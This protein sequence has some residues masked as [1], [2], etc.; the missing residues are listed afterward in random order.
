MTS[1]EIVNRNIYAMMA[2]AFQ[3]IRA[4]DTLEDMSPDAFDHLHD[5]CAE[6]LQRGMSRQVKLGL[7]HD[8]RTLS[9][10]IPTVR[11]KIDVVR[12]LARDTRARGR[13]VCEFDEYLP[14]TPHN[15]AIKAVI[16]LLLRHG[17]LKQERRTALRLLLPYLHAVRLVAPTEII[18]DEL[19]VNRL[20]ASY[21]QLLGVCELVVRGMIPHSSAGGLTLQPW[22]ADEAMDKLYERFLVEYF[23]FHHPSVFRGASQ[24]SWATSSVGSPRESQLP[25]MFSD[26]VLRTSNHT[27][28]VD[29]KYYSAN[30]QVNQWGKH[31]VHSS[32][33]YQIL[34]YVK[35]ADDASPRKTSGLLLYAQTSGQQQPDLDVEILGNRIGA[36]TLRVDRPWREMQA[37]LEGL[38][39]WL[40]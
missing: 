2:Y 33:L 20:N 14:D 17:S 29:A 13:L 15:R 30:M 4:G 35:N 31:S 1:S 9:R 23:R 28:I 37:Q 34:A 39:D 32:N 27:L 19:T 6:I 12:T 18:W 24:I 8:Y 21:R 5:L 3:T 26:L 10:E 11:G 36:M 7:H 38:I 22:I 25:R 16:I 40:D